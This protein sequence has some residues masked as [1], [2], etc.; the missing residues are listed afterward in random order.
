MDNRIYILDSFFMKPWTNVVS[1]GS[2][3]ENVEGWE[4]ADA[5]LYLWVF[6]GDQ[7]FAFVFE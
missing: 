7:P 5:Q 1:L 3:L 2:L 6:S 4:Q